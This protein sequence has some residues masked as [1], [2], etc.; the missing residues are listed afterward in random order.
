M[1][2]RDS[3]DATNDP[4]DR[5]F[6]RMWPSG[7]LFGITFTRSYT[8][9]PAILWAAITDPD[10]LAAWFAPVRG[11][12]VPGGRYV[13]AFGEETQAGVIQR[14]EAPDLLAFTW[15]HPDA[16][17]SGVTLRLEG[18]DGGTTLTLEHDRLP[19]GGVAGY[20][21]GWHAYLDRLAAAVA[22]DDLPDWVTRWEDTLGEYKRQLAMIPTMTGMN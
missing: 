5:G 13:I 8:V 4:A 21:A 16:D 7:D 14:C 6:G 22:G 3:P 15:D 18:S 11:D 20:S 17:P 9:D 12:L 1:T 19:G 10:A 2:H